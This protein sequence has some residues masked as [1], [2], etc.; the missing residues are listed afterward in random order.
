MSQ[1]LT[2]SEYLEYGGTLTEAEFTPLEFKARKEIDY[3]TDCRVQA[4]EEVPEAVKL[5]MLSA[6]NIISSTG[7]E[8]QATNP[9]VTSFNTD[10]YSESYGH[11][12]DSTQSAQAVHSTIKQMLYGETDDNGIMLVYRGC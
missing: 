5:C 3:V 7:T 4:M 12:F 11:V 2:Y 6:I 8:A 10:G 9:V 1:Y